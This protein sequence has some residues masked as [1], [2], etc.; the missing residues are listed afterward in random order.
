MHDQAVVLILSPALDIDI[1]GL[2]LMQVQ[3]NSGSS[4]LSCLNFSLFLQLKKEAEKAWESDKEREATPASR[5]KPVHGS[6]KRVEQFRK[7]MR[8]WMIGKS[9]WLILTLLNGF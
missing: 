8:R 9:F 1:R 7:N 6:T 2:K 4:S 3:T 5:P